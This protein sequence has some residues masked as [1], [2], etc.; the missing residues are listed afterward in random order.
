MEC[1]NI[2]RVEFDEES[3]EAIAD[4]RNRVK[5]SKMLA[6]AAALGTVAVIFTSRR[7]PLVAEEIRKTDFETF[8]EAIHSIPD[9]S[10]AVV[11]REAGL[12]YLRVF[13]ENDQS[14]MAF[15]RAIYQGCQIN[16]E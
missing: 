12:Q 1:P 5:L 6:G 14:Q 8:A 15:W 10:H 2:D 11:E 9:I 4:I 16:E 3:R 13:K 7:V